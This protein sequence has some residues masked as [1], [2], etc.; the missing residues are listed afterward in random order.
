MMQQTPLYLKY[1][2]GWSSREMVVMPSQAKGRLYNL[3][4]SLFSQTQAHRDMFV[5]VCVCVK[6][7]SILDEWLI[8]TTLY[9]R[10]WII[11]S[12]FVHSQLPNS[13]SLSIYLLEIFYHPTLSSLQLLQISDNIKSY[14]IYRSCSLNSIIC[15]IKDCGVSH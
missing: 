8:S 6:R 12:P 7:R 1:D 5:C 2:L 10:Q 11:S 13:R 14:T 3:L 4:H 15:P 9:H